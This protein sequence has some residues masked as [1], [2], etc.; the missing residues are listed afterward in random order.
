MP[1]SIDT[2]KVDGDHKVESKARRQTFKPLFPGL[3]ASAL[4]SRIRQQDKRDTSDRR[5]PATD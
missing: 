2:T 4:F 5:P 1:S 3:R